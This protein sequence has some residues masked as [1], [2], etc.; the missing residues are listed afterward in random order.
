MTQYLLRSK[1][2][3]FIGS[4]AH[5]ISHRPPMVGN[6]IRWIYDHLPEDYADAI[7]HDNAAKIIGGA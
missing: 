5:G 6:G 1:M 2:V 7:V 3:S 4:D